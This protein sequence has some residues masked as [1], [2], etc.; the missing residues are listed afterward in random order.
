LRSRCARF[1]A[2]G[3]LLIYI[4]IYYICNNDSV[5]DAQHHQEPGSP[6][7]RLEV[8]MALGIERGTAGSFSSSM[9]SHCIPVPLG[10]PLQHCTSTQTYMSTHCHTQLSKAAISSLWRPLASRSHDEA[11]WF[12]AGMDPVR[13]RSR[14]ESSS[15]RLETTYLEDARDNKAGQSRIAPH[16]QLRDRRHMLSLYSTCYRS[17]QHAIALLNMLSLYST[18]Y[19]CTQHAFALPPLWPRWQGESC[20]QSCELDGVGSVP[21]MPQRRLPAL[22]IISINNNVC[23]C[24]RSTQHAIPLLNMLSL[25][26]TCYCSTQHE[27]RQRAPCCASSSSWSGSSWGGDV[28]DVGS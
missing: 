22:M 1:S 19:R 6:R 11:A 14:S 18:C 4:Y 2:T 17:T 8:L 7:Q 21:A 5:S 23:F 9:T 26:S 13:I 27:L 25:Y 3:Q 16:L 10:C 15:V 28:L 20:V 12:F 24:Y